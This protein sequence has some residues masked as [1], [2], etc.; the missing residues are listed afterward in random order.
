MTAKSHIDDLTQLEAADPELLALAPSLSL[1]R[2]GT[3]FFMALTAS[4]ALML[5]FVLRLDVAYLFAPEAPRALG[6]VLAVSADSLPVNAHVRLE[7]APMVAT[8][9]RYR[10]ALGGGEYVAFALAGQRDVWVQVPVASG[11]GD[12]IF[13][14]SSFQGRLVR[15]R[16]LGGRF[17]SVQRYLAGVMRQPVDGDAYI[18][19][20]DEAPSDALWAAALVLLVLG[21]VF[22]DA[23]L[24]L[25]W[26]RP[27]P[28][29]Q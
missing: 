13:A 12:R 10:R 26:F 9:V 5:A 27:I 3:F 25:R 28:L 18:L 20:A 1:A 7:G 14:R 21:F 4:C 19:L 24:L 29:D 11:E 23:Y 15:M 17:D 16:D 8:S 2:W 22:V 6:N